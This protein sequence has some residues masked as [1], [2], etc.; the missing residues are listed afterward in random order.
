MKNAAIFDSYP[1]F[2][3]PKLVIMDEAVIKYYRK[4]LRSGFKYAGTV[5]NPDIFIDTVSENVPLCGHAGD[6]LHLYIHVR[7]GKIA[8]ARYLC[9]C[10]PTT[11]VVVE[12]LCGL[13]QNK[14]L[15]EV[16]QINENFFSEELASDGKDLRH[17]AAGLLEL[18]HRGLDRYLAERI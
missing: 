9:T 11:N 5:D 6:Y 2:A 14:T 12:I 1:V 3:K 7:D 13:V 17:K 18:L 4:L 8:A 16:K 15:A 10:E